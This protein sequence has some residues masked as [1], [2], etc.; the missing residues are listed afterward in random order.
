MFNMTFVKFVEFDWLLGQSKGQI[1][2]KYSNIL[3]LESFW[4]IKLKLC[5]HAY[6]I[7]IYINYNK[8]QAFIFVYRRS[9]LSDTKHFMMNM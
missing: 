3:F 7:R 1:Y 9:C 6:D 8:D 2:V 4:G 5:I